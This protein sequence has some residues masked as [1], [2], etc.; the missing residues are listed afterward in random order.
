[1]PVYRNPWVV[2]QASTL[3]DADE[4]ENYSCD[5]SCFSVSFSGVAKKL[6]NS[7]LKLPSYVDKEKTF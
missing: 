1:M 6:P 7:M 3:H 5:L 4:E 2:S